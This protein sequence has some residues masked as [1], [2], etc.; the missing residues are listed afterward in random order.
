[1]VAIK[2]VLLENIITT[3]ITTYDAVASLKSRKN[4]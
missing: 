2:N 4:F 3:K 1:M